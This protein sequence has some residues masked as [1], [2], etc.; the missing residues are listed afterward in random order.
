MVGERTGEPTCLTRRPTTASSSITRRPAPARRSSSSTSSPATTA[1]GRRRS[2]HFAPALPLHHFNARGYPPSDV[3]EDGGSYS[4]D[5]AR[6]DIRGG[7]RRP[8][9][10]NGPCRRPVDGRVRDAAF[11]P[12]PI[13]RRAVAGGRRLR[14]RRASASSESAFRDR[15][16]APRRVDD[17]RGHGGIRRELRLGPTRVQFQNKDPRGFAQFSRS[18]REHSALG[19]ANTQIGVQASARRSTTWSTRCER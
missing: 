6:D 1:A 18:S 3:P 2:R 19:A 14:L 15:V 7:A 8:R 13:P 16:E 11:R 10:S 4:Q 5:R 9:A 17:E 12:A